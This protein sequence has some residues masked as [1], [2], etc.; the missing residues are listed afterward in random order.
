[1]S[2]HTTNGLGTWKLRDRAWG[3]AILNPLK[4][5]EGNDILF[6]CPSHETEDHYDRHHPDR[7]SPQ[8]ECPLAP[9]TNHGFAK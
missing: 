4:F 8:G 2:Y 5:K 3:S 7:Y 9:D 6:K 1:M